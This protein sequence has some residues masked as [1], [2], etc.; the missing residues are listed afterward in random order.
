[1]IV[2]RPRVVLLKDPVFTWSLSGDLTL[3][4]Y[5]GGQTKTFAYDAFQRVS[6]IDFLDNGVTK[7]KT[8]NY[9]LDGSLTS[10]IETTFP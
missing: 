5:A 8:F 4:T 9:A 10:V 7:R 2:A 6:T 3:V 1:M